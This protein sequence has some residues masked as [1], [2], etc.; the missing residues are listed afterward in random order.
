MQ[1]L[2]ADPESALT[3]SE[4]ERG[5]P[6]YTTQDFDGVTT[7]TQSADRFPNVPF[8]ASIAYPDEPSQNGSDTAV[9]VKAAGSNAESVPFE[10]LDMAEEITSGEDRLI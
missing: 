7:V 1:A 2:K 5:N 8:T 6:E 10:D 3:P 4:Q 9:V